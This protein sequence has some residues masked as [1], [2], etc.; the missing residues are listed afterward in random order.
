[1]SPNCE[2]TLKKA[3]QKLYVNYK[4]RSTLV[5]VVQYYSS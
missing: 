4:N 3:L 5:V 1:M 2:T